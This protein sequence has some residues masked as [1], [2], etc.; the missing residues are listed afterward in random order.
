[1]EKEIQA[2]TGK[3]AKPKGSDGSVSPQTISS[4]NLMKRPIHRLTDYI[5][6]INPDYAAT[7]TSSMVTHVT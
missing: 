1:M 2:S 6:S 7:S 3:K 4:G 5:A